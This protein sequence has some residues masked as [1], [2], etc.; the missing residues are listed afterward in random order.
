MNNWLRSLL[1]LVALG[2]S[3][4]LLTACGGGSDDG[5]RI[6][7]GG[8]G[9]AD[10]GGGGGNADA[11]S[12]GDVTCTVSASAEADT[13]ARTITAL[14]ALDCNGSA[15]LGLEVCVQWDA[16]GEF[17]DVQCFT[18]I[19]SNLDALEVENVASCG[20]T[21]GRTFRARVSASVDGT[22]LPE[23]LSAELGC[24]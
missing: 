18:R 11:R 15:T 8:S 17:E 14:G 3:G 7:A 24:E 5:D 23:E 22:D 21:T 4:L 16:S 2:F 6:D 20:I 1:A 9:G 13:G 12:G 19:E 10:A